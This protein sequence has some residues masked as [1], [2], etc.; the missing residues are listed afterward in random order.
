MLQYLPRSPENCL[1]SSPT[2]LPSKILPQR[3]KI[4]LAAGH[5]EVYPEVT[6]LRGFELT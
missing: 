1:G 5:V 2:L 4:E 3:R 6:P